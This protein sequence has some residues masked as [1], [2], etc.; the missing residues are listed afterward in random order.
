MNTTRKIS[1]KISVFSMILCLAFLVGCNDN[2]N[3]LLSVSILSITANGSPL[4]D[5]ASN[6]PVSSVIE[7]AFSSEIV[8]SKFEN[9]LSITAG[10]SEFAY[11]V[12]YS[13]V[14]SKAT[15]VLAQME[16]NETYN[17]SIS[18]GDL[19]PKG[20]SFNDGI[21]LSYV[22][23]F[24]KTPCLSATNACIQTLQMPNDSGAQF[25]FDMYSNY[26]FI[27]DTEFTYNSINQLV[28]VVHGLQRN[29]NDY[30]SYMTTLLQSINM[31]G[32]S[33]LISPYFKDTQN[34]SADDLY[35]DSRWREGADS[36]NTNASIS[37][38][39]VIDAIIEKVVSSGNFPNLSTIFVT[40]HSSGGAFV[41]HYA[42]ANKVENI[43]TNVNF[44]YGIANNQYFYY[45]DGVRYDE[46]TQQFITPSGCS[47][48][49]F[50]PYGY[51]LSVPYLDG[52]EQSIITE[53][54][55]TRSTTY[56]L[57]SN[58]TSTTGSLNTSDCQ[59]TLLGS[60]RVKRGENLFL[61]MQTFYGGT[62]NH[63]KII[64][65]N[66]GHDANGMYNSSEFQQYIID[67]Q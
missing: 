31:E 9:L 51:Q 60:N 33:L 48:Y 39:T 22:T 44:E 7:V 16:A 29:A 18:V 14:S 4:E 62:N 65:N 28:I 24:G 57:G 21:S 38:F 15:I 6:I 61:Y 37:S 13:N 46:N 23:N 63:E 59:A 5:G 1:K 11:T 58:D 50:W 12:S 17:L 26:D 56:F 32:S 20:E 25:N 27:D 40:G 34:A 49:D 67:H 42:L 10:S 54:Q 35:W 66:V 64:V 19:G 30:F 55:I 45:P 52:I 47:G 53:Q 8:P 3:D 43:H 36:G 41:Q 2:D